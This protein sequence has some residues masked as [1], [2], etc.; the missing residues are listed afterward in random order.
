MR[1]TRDVE[2]PVWLVLTV[3]TPDQRDRV[4]EIVA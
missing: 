1:P 2:G 4:E 3:L